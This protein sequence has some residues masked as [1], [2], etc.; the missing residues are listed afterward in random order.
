V[1]NNQLVKFKDLIKKDLQTRFPKEFVEGVPLVKCI[2][3]RKGIIWNPLLVDHTLKIKTRPSM[4]IRKDLIKKIFGVQVTTRAKYYCVKI[5]YS[6]IEK[7]KSEEWKDYSKSAKMDKVSLAFQSKMLEKI[8]NDSISVS[9]VM[10]R[11]YTGGDNC[12]SSL[13]KITNEPFYNEGLDY[14][15]DF[16][17]KSKL[18]NTGDC[19]LPNMKNIEDFP[20]HHTKKQIAKETGELT[21]LL[22]VS[23]A[24]RNNCID[25]YGV[26]SYKDPDITV[27]CLGLAP[28]VKRDIL[29]RI[30]K[31]DTSDQQYLCEY[32]R[33]IKFPKSKVEFF[34]DFETVNGIQ[35]DFKEFPRYGGKSFIFNIG[36]GYKVNDEYGFRGF[37]LHQG[38]TPEEMTGEF[39]D[40][41]RD[42]CSKNGT[43]LKDAP[44]YH[45]TAAEVTFWKN[46]EKLFWVDLAK[47]FIDSGI[48]VKGVYNYKLK[49]ISRGLK[50]FGLLH[51][52]WDNT[53]ADGL[54]AM[55][56]YIYSV[57]ENSVN[58][59][60]ASGVSENERRLIKK[61][62]MYYNEVDCKVLSE[63]KDFMETL[64]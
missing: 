55:T 20:W 62:I 29:K 33:N 39:V 11:R 26:K 46:N 7:S 13:G 57:S 34:V 18:L 51:T 27:D 41:M 48:T 37:W 31:Q 52:V 50:S 43:E 10:G 16:R 12:Y 4:I 28:G 6:T 9:F 44:V 30:L 53:F 17:D 32:P 38:Q 35:D 63:I 3:T 40:F 15:S 60:S 22:Y 45:W 61:E 2:S 36:C 25:V 14:L 8:T 56:G 19:P 24:S 23:A 21:R 58:E 59:N 42:I 1:I 5:S 47:I 54:A 49:N 64:V